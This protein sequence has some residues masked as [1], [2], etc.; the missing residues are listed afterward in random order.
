MRLCFEES[1]DFGGLRSSKSRVVFPN[2]CPNVN[3]FCGIYPAY[4]VQSA[5][6]ETS[7]AYPGM[8]WG[9]AGIRSRSVFSAI[10]VVKGIGGVNSFKFQSTNANVINLG[11]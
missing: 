6:F 9:A 2:V 1:E 10:A 8:W 11:Q 3:V 7:V 4:L 5:T